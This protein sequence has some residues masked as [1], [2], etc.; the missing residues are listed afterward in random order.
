MCYCYCFAFIILAKSFTRLCPFAHSFSLSFRNLILFSWLSDFC[1]CACCWY[2][3]CLCCK[4]AHS[5]SFSMRCGSVSLNICLNNLKSSFVVSLSCLKNHQECSARVLVCF[6]L[7]RFDFTIL[8]LPRLSVYLCMCVRACAY[9]IL[10]Y[11]HLVSLFHAL[12]FVINISTDCWHWMD[13]V[14][15][16]HRMRSWCCCALP[17]VLI[18]SL[19]LCFV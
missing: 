3:C 13:V 14:L 2:C 12:I 17:V 11:I 4:I 19:F 6:G 9:I 15:R 5:I 8:M 10:Y 7:I 1:S 16:V 18:F